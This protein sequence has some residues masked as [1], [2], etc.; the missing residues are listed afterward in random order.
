MKLLTR[1]RRETEGVDRLYSLAPDETAS[2][3][4]RW[5]FRRNVVIFVASLNGV[6]RQVLADVFDLPKSRISAIVREFTNL[7]HS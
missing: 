3:G 1:T 7:T 6:S 5:R 2:V 4:K